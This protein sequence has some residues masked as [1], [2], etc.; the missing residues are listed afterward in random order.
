MPNL[1]SQSR[2][3]TSNGNSST[4]DVPTNGA[5]EYTRNN[6]SGCK[7]KNKNNESVPITNDIQIQ[8]QQYDRSPHKR[9]H[10]ED[11]NESKESTSKTNDTPFEESLATIILDLDYYKL[12]KL[13]KEKLSWKVGNGQ[14]HVQPVQRELIKYYNDEGIGVDNLKAD[15]AAINNY[16][17]GFS[18]DSDDDSD[19][20]VEEI[21][22]E[23]SVAA[24]E[25][26][27]EEEDGEDDE[28]FSFDNN[29]DDESNG[30]D[31]L[32]I[33]PADLPTQSSTTTA[34][35]KLDCSCVEK[36]LEENREDDDPSPTTVNA[37]LSRFT[38][39]KSPAPDSNNGSYDKVGDDEDALPTFENIPAECIEGSD[40]AVSPKKGKAYSSLF[41]VFCFILVS[42]M[43][44][45]SYNT[46]TIVDATKNVCNA[47]TIN[48]PPQHFGYAPLPPS[49]PP[50]G[51]PTHQYSYQSIPNQHIHPQPPQHYN[52]LPNYPQ[53]PPTQYGYPTPPNHGYYSTPYQNQIAP[54]Y[55]GYPAVPYSHQIV[56]CPP[57][58][59]YPHP[60]HPPHYPN[61]PPNNPIPL[62]PSH[63]SHPLQ[64]LE[65]RKHTSMSPQQWTSANANELDEERKKQIVSRL[66][67]CMQYTSEVNS[68]TRT[69]TWDVGE[70]R[71]LVLGIYL[72]G[73]SNW[74]SI[75]HV[76]STR[77]SKQVGEKAN[78]WCSCMSTIEA[79]GALSSLEDV[80]EFYKQT[81][82]KVEIIMD[83]LVPPAK[84]DEERDKR[85]ALWLFQCMQTDVNSTSRSGTWDIDEKKRLL[86][87][88]Y[89]F[90]F[91]NWKLI[92]LV[93]STRDYAQVA[94]KAYEWCPCMSTI[95]A[96][97]ALSTLEDVRMFY[98]QTLPKVESIINQLEKKNHTDKEA[99]KKRWHEL[100]AQGSKEA[101][102]LLP[103]E[104]ESASSSSTVSFNL[105]STHS[106]T[107][108][109]D[110]R[111][112]NIDYAKS[113][114]QSYMIRE[115]EGRLESG[116][117]VSVT[118]IIRQ[119]EEKRVWAEVVYQVVKIEDSKLQAPVVS[120]STTLDGSADEIIVKGYTFPP[121]VNARY[122]VSLGD[123]LKMY[124]K[125]SLQHLY[126][127]DEVASL[128]TAKRVDLMGAKNPARRRGRGGV[129]TF[130]FNK[131]SLPSLPLSP[132]LEEDDSIVVDDEQSVEEAFVDYDDKQSG[133]EEFSDDD[134]PEADDDKE[135]HGMTGSFGGRLDWYLFKGKNG[136]MYIRIDGEDL[137]IEADAGL[138]KLYDLLMNDVKNDLCIPPWIKRALYIML[139]ERGGERFGCKKNIVYL[140]LEMALQLKDGHSVPG[141]M[142][143]WDDIVF[144][145]MITKLMEALEAIKPLFARFAELKGV[146]TAAIMAWPCALMRDDR[147]INK[148][149]A[150]EY[151]GVERVTTPYDGPANPDAKT[152]AEAYST[153][154]TMKQF[155]GAVDNIDD[156]VE[157]AKKHKKDGYVLLL[158]KN[159]LCTK[160]AGRSLK[161][162]LSY[163]G[164]K[165]AAT[166]YECPNDITIYIN[167]KA[168][169][170]VHGPLCVGGTIMVEHFSLDDMLQRCLVID[171]LRGIVCMAKGEE[172]NGPYL[173]IEAGMMQKL[174]VKGLHLS[175]KYGVPAA[176]FREYLNTSRQVKCFDL[177]ANGKYVHYPEYSI[178]NVN[179]KRYRKYNK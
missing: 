143:Q 30:T 111:H 89:L 85:I 65:K 161:S 82:P 71:R 160:K 58:I 121:S 18:S 84:S 32:G 107:T 94:Q 109:L 75:Q 53:Q 173:A 145:G 114:F 113:I 136:E 45:F 79:T 112:I 148:V 36:G 70:K 15:I 163:H 155:D 101:Q 152:V 52:P 23:S 115:L 87:G 128:D 31:E 13:A 95:E 157:L 166:L 164:F 178:S 110:T 106:I 124:G 77:T 174:L 119:T 154:F 64:E 151:T 24:V 68:I 99:N 171:T 133:E 66:L 37:D 117:T 132:I 59:Q 90:G 33:A 56:G 135:K 19:V 118:N 60:P 21:N 127:H 86:L 93:V 25:D 9:Q 108:N 167:G 88:I 105:G 96:T 4:D 54:Q 40:G 91:S 11:D 142:F 73:F 131:D 170:V 159:D 83:Q 10:T 141:E 100:C 168:M 27:T 42:Q 150:T 146:I 125:A 81:L 176:F 57:I 38:N 78:G 3:S 123:L 103:N 50:N 175:R 169:I 2:N 48:P 43:I 20:E 7:R 97:G 47:P 55:Y 8:R 98:Q 61:F 139:H 29:G 162:I 6:T 63:P 74:K 120:S 76:V 137:S 144:I 72:F 14:R 44:Q 62:P 104:P 51:Y 179:R 129:Y 102:Q 177:Y 134:E 16:Y 116:T 12:C 149:V 34:T 158:D 39:D 41:I 126:N 69:G 26:A 35:L 5:V 17:D 22:K 28:G 130:K 67:Q 122:H 165:K 46:N 92:Q 1:R 147:V 153:K 140:L 172:F 80:Q 138:C 49:Y 156:E